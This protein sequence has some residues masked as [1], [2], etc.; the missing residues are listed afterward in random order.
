MKILG[1]VIAGGASMRMTGQEKA[2]LEIDGVSLM[3]RIM[4]RLKF[5][6]ESVAINSNGDLSRFSGFGCPVFA[7]ILADVGTPLAGLHAALTFG[8]QSGFDA[9]I[10]VPSDA[11][12]IPLD[13]V[14]RLLEAGEV[15]G[16]AIACSQGHDHYLTGIWTTALAQPL[17]NLILRDGLRRVQDFVAKAEAA[18]VMWSSDPHDAFFNINTPEDLLEAVLIARGET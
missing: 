1:V 4:S 5:Q 8:S 2:F 12:F 3:E 6:V 15:T 7:D 18:K 10:T 17:E 16:A 14:E 9:V 11:P 13:M